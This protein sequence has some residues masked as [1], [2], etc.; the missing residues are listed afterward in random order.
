MSGQGVEVRALVDIGATFMCV[1][2]EIAH[3]L[4]FDTTEVSQQL[5]RTADGLQ[6]R[7]PKIAPVEI[8]FGNR[9]YVTEAVVLGDQPLMG[10][11]P[12]EAMDLV[13]DPR[14]QRLAVNPDHPNYPVASAK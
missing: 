2:E 8:S 1:T 10:M 9:T 7:V 14:T 4:G 5:V 13:E 11:L 12:M 3:Q 6:I